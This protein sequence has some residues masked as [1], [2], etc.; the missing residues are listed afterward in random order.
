[1]L[2]EKWKLI[3]K[4]YE[5]LFYFLFCTGR[6]WGKIM[7][8][9]EK[10]SHWR[11]F[12][13]KIQCMLYVS[14]CVCESSRVLLIKFKI[15]KNLSLP[16]EENCHFLSIFLLLMCCRWQKFSLNIF[17]FSKTYKNGIFVYTHHYTFHPIRKIHELKPLY[18]FSISIF[19]L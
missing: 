1:M 7:W 4:L 9:R 14:M 18:L 8:W 2:E 11:T 17:P 6:T 3:E 5:I 15:D 12:C 10:L 13:D 19:M 16:R